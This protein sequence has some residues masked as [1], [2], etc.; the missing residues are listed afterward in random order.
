MET[1]TARPCVWLFGVGVGLENL[2]PKPYPLKPEYFL[3]CWLSGI[4]PP[5]SGTV[6]RNKG[7]QVCRDDLLSHLFCMF[8]NG[9]LG[10]QG[11]RG[12]QRRGLSL[13]FVWFSE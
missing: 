13:L 1:E 11:L 3:F 12:S 7:G 4:S 10:T 2:N 9:G 5:Q 8:W 6:R